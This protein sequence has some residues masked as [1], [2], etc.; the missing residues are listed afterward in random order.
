[1]CNIAAY[2]WDSGGE[3]EEAALSL[4]PQPPDA[5]LRL[6]SQCE[7]QS[8]QQQLYAKKPANWIEWNQAQEARVKCADAW[9]KAGSLSHEKKVALL[10]E[11]LVML[12]H[13]VRLYGL[14][15]I[16]LDTPT[17]ELTSPACAQVMPP[18]RVG[19]VRKL[20]WGVTLKKDAPGAYR[21]DMT[22]ARFSICRGG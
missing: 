4:V 12:F 3:I 13:T 8:K 6:R 11:Y 21:L 9:A 16:L 1:L 15:S 10:K 14:T 18:D 5:L 17:V 22:Q 19:I 2:W 7:N 20:R